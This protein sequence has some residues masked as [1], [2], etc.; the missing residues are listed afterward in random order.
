MAAIGPSSPSESALAKTSDSSTE[1]WQRDLKTLFDN[2][3]ERFPDVVW[4]LTSEYDHHDRRGGG[5]VQ[6][7]VWGHKGV[8]WLRL[9]RTTTAR[10]IC[11]SSTETSIL[12]LFINSYR[13]C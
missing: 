13:L 12:D 3:K 9:V 8:C 6:E 11:P 5:G 7:D 4:E 2:S 1:V 10:A